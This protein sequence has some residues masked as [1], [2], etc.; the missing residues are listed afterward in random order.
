MS[1]MRGRGLSLAVGVYAVI[2]VVLAV[3]VMGGS[4]EAVAES[5]QT[6]TEADASAVGGERRQVVVERGMAGD[7][8]ASLLL[9]RG[10]I[11]DARRFNA[12][13]GYSGAAPSLQSGCY[14]LESGIPTAE[15]IRRLT[16]G[17]TTTQALVIPEGLRLEQIGELA[18]DAGVA[19]AEQWDAAVA[20][21]EGSALPAGRGDEGLNGYLM[22][23]AYPVECD[24]NATSF[25][26]SMAATFEERVTPELIAE[27]EAQG[28]TLHDVVT[29]A[30]IVEREAVEKDEQP[31]VASV[32][33]NRLD[34]GMA[35]GADPT[36]QYALTTLP[37]RASVE[38]F[39]WWKQE[40]TFDDLEVD[41]PYNTYV[42]A[43]LPPGPIANAGLDAIIAT[44]RPAETEFL[45]FV[46]KGDG[47]HAFSETFE[48]HVANVERYQSGG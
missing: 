16:A 22:P 17:E 43:G 37:D 15:V 35:L 21:V 14:E 29:L 25:V 34:I 10:V 28:L 1:G 23:A 40:L 41:S 36:V 24:T 48:E 42:N 20:S 32:F 45:Y 5:L 30:S 7:A 2:L 33:R 12:L 9:D 39:G 13:L 26:E 8:I 4:D 46:A 18:I 3:V 47:S 11:D 38:Q 44:I 6:S 27:A 31:L 19:T